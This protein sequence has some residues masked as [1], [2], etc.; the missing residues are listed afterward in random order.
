MDIALKCLEI[1]RELY[2]AYQKMNENQM[3]MKRI[4]M[5]IERLRDPLNQLVDRREMWTVAQAKTKSLHYLLTILIEVND[6]VTKS[7]EET[8][9]R[10]FLRLAN[11]NS[12]NAHLA[13]F[14]NRI[15]E[16]C[17]ELQF[18]VFVDGEVQRNEDIKD[19]DTAFKSWLENS[20]LEYKVSGTATNEVLIELQ[21]DI[22]DNHAAVIE[23][24]R[25]RHYEPLRLDELS[26]LERE[27]ETLK[28]QTRERFDEILA[29]LVRIE[30]DQH[31]ILD[32]IISNTRSKT[33][34]EKREVCFCAFSIQYKI[35]YLI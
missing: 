32:L 4:V 6:F 3:L 13:V 30:T 8:Y 2:T 26:T 15:S 1:V 18:V 22:S 21:K 29:S 27:G 11:R 35:I 33:Q 28:I 12:L 31:H 23:M 19:S 25:V 5:R 20:I 24:L 34:I 9:Y 17:V 14:N 16:C 7:F 10:K